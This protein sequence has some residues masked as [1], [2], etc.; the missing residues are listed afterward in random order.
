PG[1]SVYLSD[2][3]AALRG[4]SGLDYVEE[5]ALFKDGVL[6]AGRVAVGLNRIVAAG[7]IRITVRAAA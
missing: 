2:V 6:Q 4:I 7:K 1:R 3:A 5:L